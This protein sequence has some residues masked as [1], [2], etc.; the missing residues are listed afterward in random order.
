MA[1]KSMVVVALPA[2]GRRDRARAA[3][4]PVAIARIPAGSGWV[5][6]CLDS[7]WRA[8]WGHRACPPEWALEP[9]SLQA[10]VAPGWAV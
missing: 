4:A 2:S 7:G 3:T 10:D 8:A 5:A 9:R 1:A 6:R